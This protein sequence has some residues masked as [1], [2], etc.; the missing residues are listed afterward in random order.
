[1]RLHC[2]PGDELICEE[3]CHIYNYEAGAYAALSGIAVRAISA[4]RNI[5]RL[6]DVVHSIRPDNEHAPRTRLLCLENT[7]N[8][9]GGRVLPVD[10][11]HQLCDWA[12]AKGLHTHLDGARLFNAALASGV[13]TAELCR[14]FDTVSVCFSKGLGAPV[15]SVL[16]GPR[17]LWPQMRRFR[18]LFGGG[19]RQ[20]GV[21]AAAALHALENNVDRLAEDHQTAQRLAKGI[22]EID[23][24]SI[25]PADVE[26]NIVV[27]RLDAADDPDSGLDAASFCEALLEQGV[28]MFPF[29][30]CHV[31]AVT[32]LHI[33]GDDIEL[34]LE[35][36]ARVAASSLARTA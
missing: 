8:K 20:S 29:S 9:G 18:K 19:M 23:G 32:H 2:Q 22:C 4:P 3:G 14:N 36:I 7:H 24:L 28:W 10:G 27:F 21:I 11:V 33:S 30:H 25:D 1:M 15:G 5:L 26:T 6:E 35:R 34:A 17:S 16:A 13:S 12:H 31:R